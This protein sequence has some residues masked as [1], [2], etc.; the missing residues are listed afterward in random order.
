MAERSRAKRPG[1]TFFCPPYFCH[2]NIVAEARPA[3]GIVQVHLAAIHRHFIDHWYIA[4]AAPIVTVILG[5]V[6]MRMRC[7]IGVRI[8]YGL[9]WLTTGFIPVEA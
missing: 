5:I 4:L 8:L 3:P 9:S 6:F 1:A 2:G 7:V